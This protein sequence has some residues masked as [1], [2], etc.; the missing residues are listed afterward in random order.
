MHSRHLTKGTAYLTSGIGYGREKLSAFGAAELDANII[1]ADTVQVSSFIPP[2]ERFP[3]I[4]LIYSHS[5]P[6]AYFCR[7]LMPTAFPVTTR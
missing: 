5:R 2:T 7:W 1:T 6:M 3:G 4:K